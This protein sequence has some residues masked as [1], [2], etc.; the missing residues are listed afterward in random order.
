MKKIPQCFPEA[1]SDGPVRI[2]IGQIL[3]FLSILFLLNLT[4]AVA[5]QYDVTI[6]DKHTRGLLN[7]EYNNLQCTT[8]AITMNMPTLSVQ[9]QIFIYQTPTVGAAGVFDFKRDKWIFSGGTVTFSPWYRYNNGV[10]D[11]IGSYSPTVTGT[12]ALYKTFSFPTDIPVDSSTRKLI[13]LIHGWNPD[14]MTNPY[15]GYSW[16]ALV[17]NLNTWVSAHPSW[18]VLAYNWGEDAATGPVL[19]I[20]GPDVLGNAIRNGTQAA[21]ISHQHGQ[22]LGP[23]IKS[24][25]PNLEQIQFIAHSAGTWNARAT[26]IYLSQQMSGVRIQ[27]TLLDP[28]IP[29]EAPDPESDCTIGKVNDLA[30]LDRIELLENYYYTNDVNGTQSVFTWR[31][32]DINKKLGSSLLPNPY[33]H[34]APVEWY[35]ATIGENPTDGWLHSLA[36]NDTPPAVEIRPPSGLTAMDTT[37]DNGHSIML[38][39][40]VSPDDAII[41]QYNIY[42]SRNAGATVIR[43][44]GDF[45]D[46]DEIAA[47]E[48][49]FM[50]H[51]VS[52][53]AGTSTYTDTTVLLNDVKYTYW[54]ES[55]KDGGVSKIIPSF[56][57]TAVEVSPAAFSVFSPSPNPFNPSTTIAYTLGESCPVS[58]T[59]YDILGREMYVLKSGIQG[60]GMHSVVWNGTGGDG[61]RLGSGVYL[62]RLT[63]GRHVHQGK[64]A[65]IR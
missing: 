59:V 36:F 45:P 39:W 28:Y 42:R 61:T 2:R 1:V 19:D 27:I 17:A 49:T 23:L 15:E 7:E 53:P 47:A 48:E 20:G 31:A 14:E 63:A 30:S 13:V 21:E 37:E 10:P 64:I 56:T 22:H 44:P 40:T 57:V 12:Y 51:I 55:E 16:P 3:F 24:K 60:V 33:N 54:I 50:I 65:L 32:Q 18:K 58:F 34:M 4:I 46:L 8:N 26:A 52:V 43:E 38:S 62:F 11:C 6:Q 35:G 29:G 5:D 9:N 25:L 41:D